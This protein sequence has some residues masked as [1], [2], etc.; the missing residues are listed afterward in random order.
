MHN[1]RGMAMGSDEFVGL[2]RG[3]S[4]GAWPHSAIRVVFACA[5]LGLATAATGQHEDRAQFVQAL[6]TER[7]LS[8]PAASTEHPTS[9]GLLAE[10]YGFREAAINSG[11][12]VAVSGDNSQVVD[13]SV[14]IPD[15]DANTYFV[16][17]VRSRIITTAAPAV[18]AMSADP[19]AA[20]DYQLGFEVTAFEAQS[21]RPL[22]LDAWARDST[23]LGLIGRTG[24]YVGQFHV[25]LTL[26]DD[27]EIRS[28]LASPVNVAVA[29]RGG[30]IEPQPVSV[31]ELGRWYDVSISVPKIEN[32]LYEI[33]VSADP[34]DA[35]TSVPLA[36]TQPEAQ[37]W[38]DPASIIGWG[39]GES[40]IL[41]EVRG[42]RDPQGLPVALR[43]Q[44]GSLSAS[45]VSLDATGQGAVT[46]RSGRESQA[47][48]EIMSGAF[49]NVAPLV[50][51]VTAPWWFLGAA[52]AGGLA[53]AFLRGRGR[54]HW[55]KA[56]AIGVVTAL[57]MCLAYA[58]GV[59]WPEK[60]LLASG[61]S[62]AAESAVFV[63]GAIGALVGVSVLIT[64]PK[65]T[66]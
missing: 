57:V 28:I 23:G 50:V 56:M 54:D 47:I 20:T 55:V 52:V 51:P 37:I 30:T 36:V 11:E 31:N 16:E 3:R 5:F 17:Q 12:V 34:N 65:A 59:D 18:L 21:S 19:E 27:P 14:D 35:G 25:A 63:L 29:A 10:R 6:E 24:T 45:R 53:G 43:A 4:F 64:K 49:R 33:S 9:R 22:K 58:I 26:R 8:D 42:M 60:V 61:I 13:S 2:S 7:R 66:A 15:L 39:I 38:S 46:L 1:G 40:T 48:V 32:D 62:N 41:I 44:D